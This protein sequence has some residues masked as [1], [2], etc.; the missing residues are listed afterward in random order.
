MEKEQRKHGQKT[1]TSFD[2]G[3]KI[4][5]A[6]TKNKVFENKNLKKGCEHF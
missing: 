5:D 2:A 3:R 1:N 6:L 4:E